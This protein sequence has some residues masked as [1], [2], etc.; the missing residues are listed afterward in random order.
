MTSYNRPEVAHDVQVI[1]LE[2]PRAEFHDAAL[3]IEREV[4][5]V[6]LAR[7][8]E[9]RWSV[10]EVMSLVINDDL[11]VVLQ[12]TT[13]CF[14]GVGAVGKIEGKLSFVPTVMNLGSL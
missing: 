8:N 7:A 2:S 6:D 3:S 1:D 4:A 13:T 10:P 12:E 14:M 5:N 9:R 11:R